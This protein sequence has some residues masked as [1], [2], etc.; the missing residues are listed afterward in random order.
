MFSS[1]IAPPCNENVITD[2][3]S[4][5][6]IETISLETLDFQQL[7]TAQLEDPGLKEILNSNHSSC[8]IEKHYFSLADVTLY[9]DMSTNIPRPFIP[10][11][12]RSKIFQHIHN[13][14]HPGVSATI[15]LITKRY[16]WPCMYQH[17]KVH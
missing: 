4:R 1:L 11:T 12:F 10:E 9:C 13:L 8:K 2:T 3:L 17:S 15:K 16:F 5:I 7:A 14:L 6:E